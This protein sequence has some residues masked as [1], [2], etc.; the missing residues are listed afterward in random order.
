MCPTRNSY[1][2]ATAYRIAIAGAALFSLVQVTSAGAQSPED[3]VPVTDAMLQNPAPADW[4]MFRRTLD[5]WGYSP[6]DQINRKNVDKNRM[7]WSRDLA[8]GT[9]EVTP[10]A[11]GGVLYVPQ[12]EDVIQAIDAVTGDL[13]WEYRRDVPEDLY[14][15]VGGNARNNRN[16]AIYDRFIIN[17]SDDNHVFAIDAM[18]GKTVWEIGRASCRERV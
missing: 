17:T 15:L 2:T 12:A 18:T 9:G 11:Y 5:S 6:L 3:F 10:L 13:I 16:I 4:L 7:V 1:H 8:V 14:E